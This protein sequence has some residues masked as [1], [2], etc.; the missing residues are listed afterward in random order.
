MG[1]LLGWFFSVVI[2]GVLINLAADYIK[3]YV[4]R[5]WAK[6]S[7]SKQLANEERARLFEQ[8]VQSLF[9]S[10]F[11]IIDLKFDVLYYNLRAV[12][13]A[14]AAL[15]VSQMILAIDFVTDLFAFGPVLRATF[16]MGVGFI[17]YMSLM[18]YVSKSR[19]AIRILQEF[20]KRKQTA[21]KASDQ[22]TT[23]QSSIAT[24]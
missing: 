7:R 21:T 18:S 2:A 5:F 9:T 11:A 14:V 10:Q 15:V 24:Q 8:E 20:N 19:N 3:P 17:S 13:L 4:D 16:V 6:Y 22:E 12:L 23:N 1:E